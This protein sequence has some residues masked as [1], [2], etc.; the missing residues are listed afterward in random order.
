MAINFPTSPTDGQV[1]QG[2]AWD[3]AKGAWRSVQINSS[4]VITSP[5][6]P[7]GA[8]AGD[9]WFNS[10]DG[11]F[12]VYY[13]NGLTTQ[14]VEIRSQTSSFVPIT[15]TGGT[16]STITV[17]GI[18]WTVHKFTTTGISNFVVSDPGTNP[19]TEY[20]L[21]GGGGG[22][23][24]NHAGGGGAGAMITGI[25]SDIVKGT[26][27][28]SVGAGGAGGTTSSVYTYT[29]TKGG[30][31]YIFG[32]RAAGGGGGGGRWNT[33]IVSNPSG[34]GSGGGGAGTRLGSQTLAPGGAGSQLYGN[35]GG[36]GFSDSTAGNGGGGGG[37]GALG[38]NATGSGAGAGSSGAGGN[39]LQSA[40]D[41]T[42]RYYAGGGSGGRWATGSVGAAGL[43]G[44]GVGGAA[45]GAAGAA[46][47]DNTGGGGGGGGGGNGL[48]GAGGSGIVIV[49]YP[50]TNPNA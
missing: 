30:P 38:G 7:T 41:G 26:Y 3:D 13:N 32:I 50:L 24:C 17:S 25:T 28:V 34:G 49:R 8:T 22:G 21:V 1:Y 36:W 27:E 35:D 15:A 29:G 11:T 42:T 12:Y 48:G 40:I 19:Y 4:A 33:D 9:L 20:L 6:V 47:T 5:T 10:N 14:W 2:Y 23:G 43:G 45:D 16:M 39:G 31:S 44:G 37:A 18:Q 46:G